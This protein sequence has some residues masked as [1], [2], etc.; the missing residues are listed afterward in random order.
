MRQQCLTQQMC[1]SK[2]SP[3]KELRCKQGHLKNALSINE[4]LENESNGASSQDNIIKSSEPRGRGRPP[5]QPDFTYDD[6]GGTPTEAMKYHV[7]KF[8]RT[9]DYDG[10]KH[11]LMPTENSKNEPLTRFQLDAHINKCLYE[12]FRLFKLNATLHHQ[13]RKAT[14]ESKGQSEYSQVLVEH[15]IERY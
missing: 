1:S 14:L 4:F 11:L 9:G 2:L 13:E 3:T 15:M 6:I 8:I 12:T 10:I 7:V 5:K